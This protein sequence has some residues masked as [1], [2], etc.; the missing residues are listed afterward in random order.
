MSSAQNTDTRLRV[1]IVDDSFAYRMFLR[2]LLSRQ[3]DMEVVGEAGNGLSATRAARELIPDVV[4]MDVSMPGMDGIE[5][6]RAM[7]EQGVG[8]RVIMVS[9]F[10]DPASLKDT[11]KAGVRTT[12]RKLPD[13]DENWS[14]LLLASIRNTG[15][16]VADGHDA[17]SGGCPAP[18]ADPSF[19]A[20]QRP[21]R[22]KP[23]PDCI[24]AVLIGA[25]TGGPKAVAQVLSE[26][27]GNLPVPVL[28]V[29]H[30]AEGFD[31]AL[32]GMLSTESGHPV[33]LVE[34]PEPLAGPPGR[35]LLAPAGRH[36]AVRDG[37][38]VLEDSPLRHSVRPAVDVLFESAADHMGGELLAVL[39][40]GMGK[41]GAAGLRTL[42]D[43]GAATLVQDHATSAVFGMPGEAI[44]LDAARDVVPLD[45]MARCIRTTLARAPAL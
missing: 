32:A 1:L 21:R 34:D 42:Y 28:M 12:H 36:L 25:S 31:A 3:P 29:I 8:A 37:L 19:P 10:E 24:R 35:F 26:L 13:R 4:L 41:D 11:L 15:K 23:L 9:A 43:L 16:A 39:L 5:A 18:D 6:A 14:D 2:E 22:R 38:I 17:V 40:T 27:P 20:R 7:H 33:R 30:V 45:Q 44:R